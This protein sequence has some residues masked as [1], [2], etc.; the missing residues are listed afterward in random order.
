V[1]MMVQKWMWVS[2]NWCAMW[3]VIII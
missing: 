2:H 3:Y 1:L